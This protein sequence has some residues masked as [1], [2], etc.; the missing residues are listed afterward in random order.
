[1]IPVDEDV[2]FVPEASLAEEAD[3]QEI[4]GRR[5]WRA[6]V[7]MLLLL[8]LQQLVAMVM[9]KMRSVLPD[10]GGAMEAGAS[11]SCVSPQAHLVGDEMR[12]VELLLLLLLLMMMMM[13]MVMVTTILLI[14]ALRI[15]VRVRVRVRVAAWEYCHFLRFG[16]GDVF[17]A[18]EEERVRRLLLRHRWPGYLAMGIAIAIRRRRS[19][20]TGKRSRRRR[21]RRWKRRSGDEVSVEDHLRGVGTQLRHARCPSEALPRH[22]D[23][24]GDGDGYTARCTGSGAKQEAMATRT[25]RMMMM[26]MMMMMMSCDAIDPRMDRDSICFPLHLLRLT[27]IWSSDHQIS[28]SDQRKSD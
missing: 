10:V 5:R 4:H 14:E 26:M 17:V 3:L 22:G 7:A 16:Y 19:R 9:V 15:R 25:T 28:A 1:M 2:S 8:L 18:K 11:R 21:R 6:V 27:Q 13:V 23:G 12:H 20:S 24:D